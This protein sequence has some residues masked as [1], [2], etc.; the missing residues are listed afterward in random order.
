MKKRTKITLRTKIYLTI[1][2]LLALTGILYASNPTPFSSGVP[3]PTGV[4]AAPDLFLV[5][6][7]CTENIDKVDCNGNASVFAVMPGFGSCREKYM[8]IAPSQSAAAGFTPRD[9]FATEGALVFRIDSVGNVTLFAALPGC[10]ASDHNGITFDHFGTYGFNMIVTCQEGNIFRIDG[11]GNVTHIAS[12]FPPGSPNAI[13]GPAVVPPLFGTHGG[14]IW[15]ADET[16]HAIHTIGLPPLYTVTL[17]FL[18]HQFAEGVYVIPNPPCSYCGNA[19]YGADQQ[20]F[21]YVWA[22]PL[23]DFAGLGGKVLLT[24]EQGSDGGD[25]SLVTFDGLNYVQTSFGPRVPG[26]DEGSAMVD[27]DVPTPTPTPTPSATFTPTPTFTPTAT[28]TATLTPTATATFT[29]TATATFT[30]TA[31]ATFTPTAT[32]TFT[33]TAT[34]TFTPTATATFTPTATATFTPTA[35]ATFTPTATATFT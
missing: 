2:G 29:P 18:H 26:V 9:V 8:T 34:A 21:Q 15:V 3:F 31:T 22:Y 4:A 13:E 35:T 1:V 17:N 25:T 23:S 24:S 7:F 12:L 30:P 16:G 11:G 14:E 10:F 32:A 33:P 5:S 28:A 20:L 27:C 6:E 19:F